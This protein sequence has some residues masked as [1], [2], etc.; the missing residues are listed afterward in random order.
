MLA[1]IKEAMPSGD[2]HSTAVTILL[3]TTLK[4]CMAQQPQELAEE[5]RVMSNDLR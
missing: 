3:I 4:T 2:V 5:S 1:A